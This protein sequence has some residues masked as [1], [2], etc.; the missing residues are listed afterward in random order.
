MPLTWTANPD[1]HLV[2]AGRYV[3]KVAHLHGGYMAVDTRLGPWAFVMT[4][5]AGKAWCE[6]LAAKLAK[7]G[8]S[9]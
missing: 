3:V 5:Q 2:A 8:R 4:V 6:Q 1:G 9:I 7:G